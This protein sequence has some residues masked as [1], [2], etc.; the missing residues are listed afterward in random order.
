MRIAVLG[1]GRMGGW[2]ARQ[3]AAGHVVAAHDAAPERARGL[4]G[5]AA[6]ASPEAVR[7]FA[8]ELLVNAVNLAGTVAAFRAIDPFLPPGCLLADLASVKTEIPAYY[9]A[10]GRRFVSVHPMFGPTFGDLGALRGENAILITESAPEGV[11]VFRALFERL[12]LRLFEL[13]FEAHDRM[14]AYSLTTPFTASLV[15]AACIDQTV[16]PGTSFARHLKIAR[17]LLG[18]DDELLA[19]ILFNPQSLQQLADITSRLEFLKQ[20]IRERDGAEL[21]ALLGRLRRNLG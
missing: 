9:R 16:V 7:D 21:R 4:D 5:V 18:E 3:L 8:P 15:F 12:G 14:M 13:S 20:V 11:A 19:E 17:G 2:L 10:C 6:L 1:A